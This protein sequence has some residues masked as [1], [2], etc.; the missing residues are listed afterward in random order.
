MNEY[1]VI[2]M[3]LIK[4]WVDSKKMININGYIVF[5]KLV[6][7]LDGFNFNFIVDELEEYCFVLKE[8]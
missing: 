8:V 1:R 2:S 5:I 6:N 7:K 4:K 3:M